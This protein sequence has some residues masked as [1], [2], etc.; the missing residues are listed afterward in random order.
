MRPY[1]VTFY[2]RKYPARSITATLGDTPPTPTAGGGGWT[3]VILPKRS[4]V[5]VWK[6]RDQLMVLTIPI[7]IGS[8]V[9]ETGPVFP[10]RN[11]LAAMWRPD[12]A[13]E[14]PP[15]IKVKALGDAVPFQHLQY[16]ITDLTWGSS[17]A[18]DVVGDQNARR[19]MQKMVVTVTEY[20]ADER[21]EA[22]KKKHQ[23]TVHG[24]GFE[25]RVKKGDTLRSI[26]KR[27]GLVWQDIADVQTPV[28]TDPRKIKVGQRLLIVRLPTVS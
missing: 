1:D 3:Q 13:T 12:E 9:D 27:F 23:Q 7:V 5:M 24:G 10:E 26:A 21:L 8:I 2:E 18:G 14:E 4:A 22:V 25:Y 15:V 28:I 17:T 11:A 6:G 16:V 19:T 20:E